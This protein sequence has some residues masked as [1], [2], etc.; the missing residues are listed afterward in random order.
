VTYDPVINIGDGLAA[1]QRAGDGEGVLWIHPY[2]LDSSCWTELWDLLPGPRHLAIDLPGHGL[3][4]PVGPEVDLAALAQRLNAVAQKHE[5][6]HL[7]GLSFGTFVALQMALEAPSA[8]ASLV[9]GSPLIEHGANDDLFWKRYRELV[10]MYQMAGHGEQLRGR[11]ML[12]EPTPFEGILA[13]EG[14]GGKTWEIVGRHAFADLAFAGLQRW[15]S[16][17]QSDVRLHTIGSAVLLIEGASE[18]PASR[19]YAR[20]LSRTFRACQTVSL[21]GAGSYSLMERPE[22]AAR[23]IEAHLGAHAAGSTVGS[24]G[25]A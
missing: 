15:G 10:T 16:Y 18:G 22:Q 17:P 8:Y 7:V 19:R 12:V 23:A 25:A 3:S 6:R 9:L 5:I 20:R 21:V 1:R 13:R 2:A 4:L 14:E 11:L 24:G